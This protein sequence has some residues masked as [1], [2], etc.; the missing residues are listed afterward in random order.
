MRRNCAEALGALGEPGRDALRSLAASADR[1]VRD[2]CLAVLQDLELADA[3]APPPPE[4]PE[5]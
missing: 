4:E 2:R 5:R 3:V 1:Y